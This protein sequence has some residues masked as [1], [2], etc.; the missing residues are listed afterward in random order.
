[1][2]GRSY[3]SSPLLE[4][5]PNGQKAF[6]ELENLRIR[7]QRENKPDWLNK[8]VFR[9]LR[10]FELWVA[11]YQKLSTK[12]GS[13]TT[14]VDKQTI[15]GTSLKTIKALQVA[16][17]SSKFKWG[18]I[19]RTYIPKPDGRERSLGIPNFQDRL[20]QGV[21]KLILESI[22]EP[23]FTD[24]SYGFRPGRSQISALRDIR[25]NFGGVIWIV[26]GD[27]TKYFDMVDH[28]I[29]IKLISKR[30]H[31]D[32]FIKLIYAG[33]KARVILPTGKIEESEL[34]VPQGGVLSPL[35]SNIFLH[36]LD[37]WM[38]DYKKSFDKGTQPSNSLEYNRIVRKP[39]GA[40]F[41]HLVK[42]R[43]TDP[44]DPNWRRIYYIRYA[45]DFIIGI[46]GDRKDAEKVK[47]DVAE[48]LKTQLNLELNKDKTKIT[49]WRENVPF[50]GYSIGYKNITYKF[51]VKG[52]Y[53][54]ARRR[55]L[56]LM[57]DTNKVI[58]KLNQA[59]FCDGKGDPKPCFQ[60]MH[61]TQSVTNT[62]IRGLL[63]GLCNYYRLANNR[64]RFTSRISYI[65]RHST[66]KMYAAKFKLKTR[67]STFRKG[68]KALDKPL[69][70]RKKQTALG[71]TDK[72]QINWFLKIK[73]K[74]KNQDNKEL[75]GIKIP[76]IP[77]IY[78]KDIPG[79]DLLTIAKNTEEHMSDPIIKAKV[80]YLRGVRAMGLPCIVC[81]TEE[82]VEMHHIRKL[83]DLKGK[84]ALKIAQSAAKRKQIPLCR[85]HHFE[86]K[87]LKT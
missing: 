37:T 28:K 43:K 6:K 76:K 48:F 53:R 66:A 23:V 73:E 12:P 75:K 65:L 80:Y 82:N 72:N 5:A 9:L 32:K 46:I 74:M 31:D 51:R 35:L 64:R 69:E 86:A 44:Q 18:E 45:D 63:L 81:G 27:I 2:Q 62:R 54:A 7:N 57:A 83:K 87:V 19:R 29:L 41:A 8:H 52:T 59:K 10:H 70:A 16:V 84:T 67:A 38:E 11:T 68:G 14:G 49:H 13:L 40:T 15:D 60:Y 26:E 61:Q 79:P 58:K 1:M 42:L 3:C 36:E 55:I 4:N 17:L 50:L 22:Y 47:I 56:T 77:Y 25:K 34:G 39:K 20:V 21:L 78:T 30:I 85:K 24:T 71:A 33:L